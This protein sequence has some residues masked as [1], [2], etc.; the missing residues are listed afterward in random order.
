MKTKNNQLN[1]SCVTSISTSGSSSPSGSA[2]YG[3]VNTNLGNLATATSTSSITSNLSGWITSADY[4]YRCEGADEQDIFEYMIKYL[5]NEEIEDLCEKLKFRNL[6]ESDNKHYEAL[7]KY[8]V[9]NRVCREKFIL[10]NVCYLEIRDILKLHTPLLHT[11]GYEALKLYIAS[12][13]K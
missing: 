4:G 1:N 8:I 13:G 5:T 2:T 3:Y 10:D 7:I 9:R 11:P 12:N 6:T